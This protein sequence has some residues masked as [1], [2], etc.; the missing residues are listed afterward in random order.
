MS[1]GKRPMGR[2]DET[3][4][5]TGYGVALDY[6]PLTVVAWPREGAQ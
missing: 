3:G 6:S 1:G 2:D 5:E 4:Y